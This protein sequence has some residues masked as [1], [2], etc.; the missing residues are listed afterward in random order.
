MVHNT[1]DATIEKATF[2]NLEFLEFW[3][4]NGHDEHHPDLSM[5]KTNIALIS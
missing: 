2:G 3:F 4:T 1:P 5:A